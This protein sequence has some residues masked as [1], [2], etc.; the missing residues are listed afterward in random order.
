M[1]FSRDVDYKP[2]KVPGKWQEGDLTVTRG[3]AW[4]AP[5]CHDGCGVLCY[6][7]KEGNLVKVEGDPEN[8]YNQGR[9]C[10]RCLA[11]PEVIKNPSRL[12]YPMKR[13]REFRGQNDKWE[14]ISW[15]EAY[16]LVE[17]NFNRIKAE[18]G[19]ESVIF[20]W[21]TGRDIA[22]VHRLCFGFGSPN[23]MNYGFSGIACFI[24]RMVSTQ[25]LQGYL[26]TVDCS[27]HFPNRYNAEGYQVPEVLLVWG[28]NPLASNADGFF[29]HWVID[30]M[31]RG[32]KIIS[33]DPRVNYLAS[34]AEL[35]LRVRPGTDGAIAMAMLNVIIAEDLYDHDFVEKWTFGFDAL[36]ERVKEC[37]PAWAA[38]I[39]WV[40]EEKIVAAARMFANAERGAVQWGLAVDQTKYSF[41][42][43]H[44]INAISAIT[45][46]VDKPGTMTP[47]TSP[48]G[49][50]KRGSEDFGMIPAEKQPSR[51]GWNEYPLIKAGIPMAHPDV[52]DKQFETGYPYPIKA[53]WLQTTN[54]IACMG[55]QPQRQHEQLKGLDFVAALDVF[56][57]PTIQACAD[58]VMPATMWP[59]NDSLWV[60]QNYQVAAIQKAVEPQGECRPDI[61]V[62]LELGRRFNPE[63]FPWKNAED[64]LSW[65]LMQG[66]GMTFPELCESGGSLFDMSLTEYNRHEK[67]LLRA[68]GQPGFNTPTGRIELYSTGFEA[69]GIEALPY[70]K[71]PP[72]SPIS[73][74]ELYEKYPLVFTS[75][76]R[77]IEMFHSE[78]RQ[79]ERLRAMHPYPE[80]KINPKD[81][82][83]YGIA[84]GQWVWIENQRGRARQKAKV[85]PEYPEGIVNADH[86]WWYPED[87]PSEPS[88]FGVWKSNVNVMIPFDCGESG[89]GSAYKSMLCKV[90]PCSDDEEP[91]ARPWAPAANSGRAD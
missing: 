13:A 66:T 58:V 49:L 28:N 17:E 68:D 83:K 47:I 86:G 14:R 84:D 62:D 26:Y 77:H 91:F 3:H 75:G 10:V 67:G 38:E 19:A 82:E 31:K 76:A 53:A 63:G 88:L 69:V 46:N 48:Y 54:T 64:R 65:Y 73:T 25:M 1:E 89:F 2:W 56:M 23:L 61:E 20:C 24:P 59:E 35:H 57:T 5:G 42:T 6:T 74:P 52:A 43:A 70:Y 41:G 7:D 30:C 81:A 90:Y 34:R 4:T 37:T 22:M 21:G 27:Q 15:D 51:I 72:E 9:L 32:T 12:L 45:G 79:V 36:V 80:L 44:A 87:D 55:T 78:H 29:G 71:E 40:P 50:D 8:P 18:Y 39:S 85:T 33:I 11:M 60:I 16:D